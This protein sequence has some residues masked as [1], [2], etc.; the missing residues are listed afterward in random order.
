MEMLERDRL[1]WELGALF[2]A[3][4]L[5]KPRQGGGVGPAAMSRH[6]PALRTPST[7]TACCRKQIWLLVQFIQQKR[8]G[9]FLRRHEP[10][11]PWEPWGRAIW[12]PENHRWRF[13]TQIGGSKRREKEPG[14]GDD[15]EWPF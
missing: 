9:P 13:K 1:G 6:P 7:P 12:A 10:A 14:S 15:A 2:Q 8:G 4:K 5:R 3:S 11:F